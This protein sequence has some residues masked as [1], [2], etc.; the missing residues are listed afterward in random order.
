MLST[1]RPRQWFVKSESQPRSRHT[2]RIS[3][4]GSPTWSIPVSQSCWAFLARDWGSL[5]MA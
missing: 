5:V 3:W 4:C 2:P 1:I